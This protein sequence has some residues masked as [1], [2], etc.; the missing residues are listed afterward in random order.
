M[1]SKY[2]VVEIQCR[3]AVLTGLSGY[4]KKIVWNDILSV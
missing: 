4:V 1:V 3:I 2:P